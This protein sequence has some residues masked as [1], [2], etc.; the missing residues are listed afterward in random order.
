MTVRKGC[1]WTGEAKEP[2]GAGRVEGWDWIA[3]VER[4]RF[5]VVRPSTTAYGRQGARG[6]RKGP[7]GPAD[8][9]GQ[10]QKLDNGLVNLCVC[11]RGRALADAVMVSCRLQ[12]GR[13]KMVVQCS[14]CAHHHSIQTRHD[15]CLAGPVPE[16]TQVHV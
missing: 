7:V 12:D 4:V 3:A 14:C 6:I 1:V 8:G 16:A 10:R 2:L 13:D 5:L 15:D 11:V 9:L